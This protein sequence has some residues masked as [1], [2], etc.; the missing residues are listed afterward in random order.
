MSWGE[1]TEKSFSNSFSHRA[2][3]P[4]RAF[5]RRGCC[6]EKF[7]EE[8]RSTLAKTKTTGGLKSYYSY[9]FKNVDRK[10]TGVYL[11]TY[12]ILRQIDVVFCCARSVCRTR[13]RRRW[14][15]EAKRNEKIKYTGV[16]V[17]TKRE[18][19][20]KTFLS[21]QEPA[22][23]NFTLSLERRSGRRKTKRK[24]FKKRL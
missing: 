2:F 22:Q 20:W 19:S 15:K 24:L 17:A 18:K 14:R 5:V 10:T 8:K 7:L 9:S 13:R 23:T 3:L 12:N 16:V 4:R 11:C 21:F 1:K 6:R